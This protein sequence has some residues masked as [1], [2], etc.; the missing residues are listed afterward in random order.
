[1]VEVFVD[2]LLDTLKILPILLI[3]HILIEIIESKA[4]SKIKMN[5]ALK[6]GFAPLIGAGV[7]IIPQCGFSVVATN[8]YA[9][10]HIKLGTLLAVFIATSDE[11][12]PILLSNP[13]AISKILPLLLIKLVFA[14]AVGYAVNLIFC[15]KKEMPISETEK[16]SEVGCCGHEITNQTPAVKKKFDFEKY[17]LHPLFHTLIILLFIFIVNMA[18]GTIIFF[19]TTERLNAFL[20]S[21]KLFQPF[22]SGLVGLIPNCAASV[23]ITQMYS[24]GGITL[25][26][27]VAG[28]S[29]NAGLGFAVLFKENKNIKQNLCIVGFLYIISSLLGLAI[30]L[31]AG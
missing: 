20:A 4:V 17:V 12:I 21:S 9:K 31:I 8:L 1:M 24:L 18:I 14:I 7:G 26:S 23:A 25:G 22:I 15:R 5:K 6:G 3:V 2:A 27:A 29:V 28:L 11:A 10:Q 16:I 30:T 13:A 19:V